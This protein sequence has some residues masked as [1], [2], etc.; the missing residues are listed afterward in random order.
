MSEPLT[1]EMS[2]LFTLREPVTDGEDGEIWNTATT[3]TYPGMKGEGEPESEPEPAVI[4]PGRL[5]RAVHLDAEHLGGHQYRIVSKQSMRVVA[6]EASPGLAECDY[7][8]DRVR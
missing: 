7:R 4:D 6:L 2:E 3:T 8:G 1:H 5:A